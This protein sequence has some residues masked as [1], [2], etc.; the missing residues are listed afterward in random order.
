MCVCDQVGEVL[1]Q[2]EVEKRRAVER[3]DFDL[4]K[5]KKD[6]CDS[7]RRHVYHQ[8]NLHQLIQDPSLL[9]VRGCPCN[10]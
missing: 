2:F 7:L 6:Y 3:E 8:L 9:Q 10:M 1:G 4:A 5:Q